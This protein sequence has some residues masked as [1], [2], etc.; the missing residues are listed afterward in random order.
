MTCCLGAC[1][2]CCGC[3]L[4]CALCCVIGKAH[5]QL[6]LLPL[7][8]CRSCAPPAA[9]PCLLPA[10]PCRP[11]AAGA[12]CCCHRNLPSAPLLLRAHQQAL[13]PIVAGQQALVQD[14]AGGVGGQGAALLCAQWLV[15]K[16]QLCGQ[17]AQALHDV[18][19]ARPAYL[20]GCAV[21]AARATRM[22]RAKLAFFRRTTPPRTLTLPAHRPGLPQSTACALQT[23]TAAPAAPS[24][25]WRRSSPGL[26]CSETSISTP[27]L[28]SA[29][30]LYVHR[31]AFP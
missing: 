20:P 31:P 7:R 25:S 11:A 1:C 18:G 28:V 29:C 4:A 13:P 2:A 24:R 19:L 17:H 26:R 3:W 15:R 16:Y 30:I 9:L 23:C 22:C 12:S 27:P 14:A 21:L 8:V 10:C 6:P 5:A